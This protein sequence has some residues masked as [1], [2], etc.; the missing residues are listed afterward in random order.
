[1]AYDEGLAE[2][3]RTALEGRRGVTEKEMFGGI[4]FLLGGKMFVGIAE[5]FPEG[6]AVA[7]RSNTALEVAPVGAR[8]F[9]PSAPAVTHPVCRSASLRV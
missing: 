9:G 4:A 2:R 3:I 7:I 6:T 1:M 5:R 8:T